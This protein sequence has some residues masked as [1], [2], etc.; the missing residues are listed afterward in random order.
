MLGRNR[1]HVGNNLCACI[2]MVFVSTNGTRRHD[3]RFSG[4]I[5]GLVSVA[6]TLLQILE[7]GFNIAGLFGD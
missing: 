2:N 4:H 5:V 3:N 6:I 1:I 7:G